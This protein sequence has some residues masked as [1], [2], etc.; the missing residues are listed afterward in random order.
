MKRDIRRRFAFMVFLC[1]VINSLCVSFSFAYLRHADKGTGVYGGHEEITDYSIY[2]LDYG[3]NDL[4]S[5]VT[6]NA[7]AI[8]DGAAAEDDGANW[9]FHFYDPSA[10]YDEMGLF[11]L[12]CSADERAGALYEKAKKS[13]S[14]ETLGH[15]LHLLQDMAS[16]SHVHNASHWQHNTRW[17]AG[18]EWWITEHWGDEVV[19]Y[20]LWLWDQNPNFRKPIVAGDMGEHV[21]VSI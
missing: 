1:V 12:F 8:K 3:D 5:A 4:W 6:G 7:V 11:G 21:E 10:P 20:L 13:K 18:Y 19:P 16:P 14:W 17:K 9:L 15:A 2:Q